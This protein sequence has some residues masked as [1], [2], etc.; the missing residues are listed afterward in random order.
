MRGSSWSELW[1]TGRCS[2]GGRAGA[3]AFPA[4]RD[5]RK[6]R[7]R[8]FTPSNATN[9]R[10]SSGS[11]RR[12]LQVSAGKTRVARYFLRASGVSRRGSMVTSV[13]PT[14]ARCSG[15]SA[16]SIR[17]RS[18]TRTGHADWQLA[19][20]ITTTWGRPFKSCSLICF[21]VSVVHFDS[22]WYSDLSLKATAADSVL[23]QQN[24][25]V[26]GSQKRWC[27]EKPE[28]QPSTWRSAKEYSFA[29]AWCR[30]A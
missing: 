1:E 17:C 8:Y 7:E 20:N 4:A 15:L 27:K 2:L 21:P 18:C 5:H 6:E 29:P 16:V 12:R 28:R 19:K 26:W 22:V 14:R 23:V 30:S 9:S 24:A 25:V 3:C 11:P 13:N 10:I